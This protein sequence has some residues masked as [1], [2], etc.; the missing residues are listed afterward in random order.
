MQLLSDISNKTLVRLSA[1]LSLIFF[2]SLF[3]CSCNRKPGQNIELMYTANRAGAVLLP[4]RLFAEMA[5]E[6]YQE[7]K[8]RLA[9]NTQYLLGNLSVTEGRFIFT[10]VVPF[11][12]GETYE[13]VF[14][15]QVL[16]TF[17][18]ALPDSVP[19]PVLT[20]I[21][22]DKDTV[23]ENLLKIYLCFSEPMREGEALRHI[24]LFNEQGDSLPGS[25]LELQPELWDSTRSVLTLWLDPG[26]IKRE[27]IPNKMAGKP[28]EKG[29]SYTLKISGAWKSAAGLALGHDVVGQFLVGERDDKIPRPEQWVLSTVAPSTASRLKINFGEPL[30]H[31]LVPE[32]IRV[33]DPRGRRVRG[34]VTVVNQGSGAE[35]LPEERWQ[36]GKYILR[37]ASHL[38]DLAGNNLV[39]KF[40]R[41]LQ[42]DSAETYKQFADRGF[43]VREKLQ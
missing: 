19:V 8:L 22:P 18:V 23:P 12:A 40:D 20:R 17:S 39:R 3:V 1:L 13:I 24:R 7:L 14:G 15:N 27:L 6:Q 28:L 2:V 32:T 43:T 10:P 35:F 41:D 25:F 21:F 5:P 9:E 38:E 42:Q 26:R 16:D 33:L 30:D 36:P 11:T 31:F 29:K 4:D 34:R 37:T